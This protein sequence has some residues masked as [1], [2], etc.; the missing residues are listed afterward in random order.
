MYPDDGL[1]KIDIAEYY[2]DVSAAMLTAVREHPLVMERFPDGINGERIV[3]KNVPGHFPDWIRRVEVAKHGGH[4]SLLVFENAAD[5]VYL[6]DQACLTPHAWLS[7]ADRPRLPDRLIFDLDPSSDL[8]APLRLAVRRVRELLE[9]VGLVPFLM[10]TGSRGFH[11]VAP[12]IP[13]CDFEEVG[14]FT[15]R[16]SAV[17]AERDP[18][19]LTTARRKLARGDRVYLDHLRNAYAQTAVAPYAVRPLPGAPVATPL[20]WDEFDVVSPRDFTVRDVIDRLRYKGDPWATFGSYARSL[21]KVLR[22]L[23]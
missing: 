20:W 6:A 3:Q 5:L 18:R 11:V 1:T 8:Q 15:S 12:L 2:R 21:R 23:G 9:A 4:N 13:E 22:R 14:D 17:L 7:R 10:T 16:A 19:T